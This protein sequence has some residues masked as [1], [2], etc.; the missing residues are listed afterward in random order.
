MAK[1]NKKLLH[2][3]RRH[4]YP[5]LA[6]A[7]ILGASAGTVGSIIPIEFA[8][9]PR[10]RAALQ[11]RD[12]QIEKLGERASRAETETAIWLGWSKERESAVK[13]FEGKIAEIEKGRDKDKA[14]LESY[15]E[16]NQ[17]LTEAVE[18]AERNVNDYSKNWARALYSVLVNPESYNSLAKLADSDLA[19]LGKFADFTTVELDALKR[20]SLETLESPIVIAHNLLE[21]KLLLPP[22]VTRS[23][24]GL[25]GAL[26]A[27]KSRLE[28]LS[29]EQ[30]KGLRDL[31]KSSKFEQTAPEQLRNII[32]S[33]RYYQ[34]SFLM[35]Y[36]VRLNRLAELLKQQHL[37]DR[38]LVGR[39]ASSRILKQHS[40]QR[41]KPRKVIART[42]AK[43]R[44]RHFA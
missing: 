33:M 6:V 19:K 1:L 3:F 43:T 7:A 2:E 36:K 13:D 40:R 15:A 30:R 28:G 25:P 12:M 16:E 44:G 24:Y 22:T 38:Y 41:I 10:Y 35:K 4:P 18:A 39:R 20:V 14:L 9:L 29:D 26:F 27:A 8:V 42:V 21:H 11:E 23:E 34:K 31:A 5:Y 32:K 17:R 37:R